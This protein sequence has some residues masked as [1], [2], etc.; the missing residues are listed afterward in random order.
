MSE[1]VCNDFVKFVSFEVVGVDNEGD[2]TV[3]TVNLDER[4]TLSP[5]FFKRWVRR[6]VYLRVD[7][8]KA[9]DI[10]QF[11]PATDRVFCEFVTEMHRHIPSQTR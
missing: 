3:S 2:P 7:F 5:A 1:L 11:N 10:E 8:I 6:I 4:L 9:V